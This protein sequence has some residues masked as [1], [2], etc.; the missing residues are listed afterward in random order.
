MESSPGLVRFVSCG[1]PSSIPHTLCFDSPVRSASVYFFRA[2]ELP[3]ERNALGCLA[4]GDLWCYGAGRPRL[5]KP[6]GRKSAV[7]VTVSVYLLRFGAAFLAG[8]DHAHGTGRVLR[9]GRDLCHRTAE[10]ALRQEV[11]P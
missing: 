6:E 2:R 10:L 5:P 9:G 3:M 1:D 8:A 7:P 4:T 11:K